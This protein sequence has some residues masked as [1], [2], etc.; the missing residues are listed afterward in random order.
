MRLKKWESI[1][2]ESHNRKSHKWKFLRLDQI[3]NFWLNRLTEVQEILTA[4]LIIFIQNAEQIQQTLGMKTQFRNSI[5]TP[6]EFWR[7][8]QP[9]RSDNSKHD[10]DTYPSNVE[11]VNNE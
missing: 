2:T 9:K 11:N 10:K 7:V 5:R 6:D 8:Q 4:S 1:E 3:H